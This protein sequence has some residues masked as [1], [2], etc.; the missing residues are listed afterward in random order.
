MSALA[1]LTFFEYLL[2]ALT[3]FRIKQVEFRENVRLSPGTKKTVWIKRVGVR[4]AEIVL[5]PTCSV[6][7]IPHPPKVGIIS[8]EYIRGVGREILRE[9]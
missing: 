1:K 7:I 3:G 9:G 2:S 5:H 8:A 4:K 6:I